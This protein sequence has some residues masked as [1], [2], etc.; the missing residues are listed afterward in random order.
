[1]NK[2]GFSLLV[3]LMLCVIFILLG[4]ALAK[5][6]Q[7]VTGDSKA[8]LNCST[9]TDNEVK[10]DCRAIDAQ[11]IFIIVILGLGLTIVGGSLI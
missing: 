10:A 9:T 5:P 1:M 8:Q 4:L 2:R 6:L 7:Q 11:M 3:T